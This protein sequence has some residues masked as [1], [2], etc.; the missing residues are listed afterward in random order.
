VE[1]S[2]YDKRW[3]IGMAAGDHGIE[4]PVNWKGDNLLGKAITQV[5]IE[6]FGK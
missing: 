3:G 5:R 2:P 1:A 6:I 4:D